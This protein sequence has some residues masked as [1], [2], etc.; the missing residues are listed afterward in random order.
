MDGLQVDETRRP[1]NGLEVT[2]VSDGGLHPYAQ[3]SD[4]FY[5]GPPAYDPSNQAPEPVAIGSAD[6]GEGQTWENQKIPGSSS[7]S[8]IVCGLKR[9]TFWI[10]VAVAAIIVIAAGVGGGVGG[11]LSSSSSPSEASTPIPTDSPSVPPSNQAPSETVN[12][13]AMN[14]TALASTSF[15][16][17]DARYIFTYF[18]HTSGEI[19]EIAWNDE[20]RS[21]QGGGDRDVVTQNARNG[22][23]LASFRWQDSDGTD[24]VRV[25]YIDQSDLLQ[26]VEKDVSN[27]ESGWI[28]TNLVDYKTEAVKGS[29][30]AVVATYPD[31]LSIRLIFRNLKNGPQEVGLHADTGLWT[32]LNTFTDAVPDSQFGI[33]TDSQD[34]LHL[35]Y[36]TEDGVQEFSSPVDSSTGSW[37]KGP[38]WTDIKPGSAIAITGDSAS[39]PDIRSLYFQAPTGNITELRHQSEDDDTENEFIGNFSAASTKTMSGISATSYADDELVHLFYQ[40]NASNIVHV[41]RSLS[42][43]RW[44]TPE[45]M[46]VGA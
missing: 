35:F 34:L 22:S 5:N 11:A 33:W 13:G 31:G 14:G 37:S 6:M 4:K 43:K 26:A 28:P 10:L 17:S 42:G 40:T 24:L 44:S 27:S 7:R 38:T 39:E 25:F 3:V 41:S 1:D 15:R 46:P 32:G 36:E 20:L 45:E 16:N 12:S 30:L 29:P 9:K 8:N 23:G 19:R 2:A 21:F 18:Q